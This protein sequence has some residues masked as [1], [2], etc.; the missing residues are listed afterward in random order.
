MND[1]AR[2]F[3]SSSY[4]IS[5]YSAGPS[6]CVSPPWI[7]P[8]TIMGLMM[9]PQSSTA[10]NRLT[11]TSPVPRS[12]STTQMYVPNGNVRFGGS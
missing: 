7:C 3:P 2:L 1:P 10:T 5:S 12:M 9:F 4:G 11:L 8:S 6:P